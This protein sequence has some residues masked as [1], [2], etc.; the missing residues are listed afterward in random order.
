MGRLTADPDQRLGAIDLVEDLDYDPLA[1][2]HATAV[3]ASSTL[4][5][6]DYRTYFAR[7]RE[8][9]APDGKTPPAA[10]TWTF[11]F[12]QA[13]RLSPGGEANSL[14]ALAALL[15]GREIPGAVFTSA[16]ACD[17]LGGDSAGGPAGRE[18][19]HAALLVLERSGLL[20]IDPTGTPPAVRMS[21]VVQAAVRAVMPAGL[22][23]RVARTAADAL[24]QVW[25]ADDPQAWL[26]G[27]LRSC[28]ASLQQA[29]GDLL[30]E[31]GCHPLLLRAGQSLDSARLTAPAVAYWGELATTSDRVLEPG[32]P[33]T[34]VIGEQ[35]AQAYLTAGLAAE[36]IAW[37]EWVLADRMRVLGPDRPGTIAARRNLG[38]ALVAANQ[39]RDALTVLEGAV[40]D[41]ERVRGPDHLDT[42]GA[43]D[44]LAAAYLA[45]GQFTEANRLYRRIL[46]DRE[47]LQGSRHPETMT[48]RLKLADA[49]LADGQ[50]KDALSL[51]KRALADRERV[52]GRDH[53]DTI[54]ARGSLGSAYVAAGRMGSALQVFEQTRTSYERV[55][56][57]DHP[58]TLACAANLANAYYTVGRLTD[59]TSLLRDTVARCERVLPPDDPLTQA[60][61]ESLTNI[62]G[63]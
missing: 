42:L 24:V 51:Y 36:A 29:A 21:P 31:G 35:L 30:W 34:V 40:G 27:R 32:H 11:S 55:L 3:I 37:F 58:D 33:D 2:T 50:L 20:A 48:T 1:L 8:Q 13:N 47:R 15:D 4:S 19:A 14:L 28:A 16:A 59:G 45:A 56:G 43:R 12:E 10:V 54:A 62:A 52:L 53:L 9:L 46:T 7:R 25:P 22:L 60:V 23:A 44:E 57:A 6:R 39:I 49:T 26:V 17:Y 5:C 38:H 18:R 63:G 61:R 41:Y